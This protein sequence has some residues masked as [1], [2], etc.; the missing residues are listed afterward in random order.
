VSSGPDELHPVSESLDEVVRGL[1]GGSTA[2]AVAGVFAEWAELV[3][4]QIAA[5]AKPVSLVE[6]RLLVEV[7]EPGWATQLRYLEAD[8]LGRLAPAAGAG[9]PTSLEVRVRRH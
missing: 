3:G 7:D 6:G 4:P 1:R 9:A 5:H 2:R 8:I